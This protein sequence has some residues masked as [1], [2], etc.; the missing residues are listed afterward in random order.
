MNNFKIILTNRYSQ[1]LDNILKD[2]LIGFKFIGSLSLLGNPLQLV[3][4]LG[5][6]VF[7]LIDQPIEAIFLFYFFTL[8]KN[9]TKKGF[10]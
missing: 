7:D 6:G 1:I 3:N 9:F 10:S 2:K 5:T 8:L 4:T